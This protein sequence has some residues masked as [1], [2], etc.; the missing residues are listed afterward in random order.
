MKKYLLYWLETGE[1]LG[2]SSAPNLDAL[3]PFMGAVESEASF[4]HHWIDPVT[5]QVHALTD[6]T[7]D[8]L[9]LPCTLTIEGI[10]YACTEQPTFS[11]AQAGDY[12]IYV[13]AGPAYYKR[14]FIYHAD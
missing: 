1:A 3:P 14:E 6:Y 7:L 9:P 11:F 10:E 8:S 5:R 12:R 4:E 2:N 13:D